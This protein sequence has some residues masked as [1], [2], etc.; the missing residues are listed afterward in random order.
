MPDS[1]HQKT[2]SPH[3]AAARRPCAAKSSDLPGR[4][5]G[6]TPFDG[7]GATATRP[8][9]CLRATSV[10]PGTNSSSPKPSGPTFERSEDRLGARPKPVSCPVGPPCRSKTTIWDAPDPFPKRHKRS[11]NARRSRSGRCRRCR[12][13]LPRDAREKDAVRMHQ[14]RSSRP[15]SRATRGSHVSPI[16]DP[17]TSW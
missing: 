7:S 2:G 8:S 16:E 5:R 14:P 1:G 15:S 12:R 3:R 17:E 9:P 4:H 10:P 6:S 11:T 13:R